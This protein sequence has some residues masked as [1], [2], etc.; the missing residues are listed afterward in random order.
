MA[1][2]QALPTPPASEYPERWQKVQALMAEQGLDFLVAYADDRATFGPAHARWLANFPVHFE[3]A[4]VLM[5]SQGTP[6]MLVGTESDAYARLIG[7]I[8]DV[9]VLREFT[10]PNED[11]PYSKIQPLAEIMAEMG[12]AGS[13]AGRP[14]WARAFGV[15][16][17]AALRAALPDVAWVDVEDALKSHN[18]KE[19]PRS[20]EDT[21]VLC[22]SSVCV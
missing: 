9:R 11:Y 17:M 16:L 1:H 19:E 18:T 22:Y 10:H 4:C 13:E 21:G 2:Q 12:R 15:D 3:P 8:A 14:G 7:Q 5:P 6:A 20:R